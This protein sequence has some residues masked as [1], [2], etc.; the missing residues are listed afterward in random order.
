VT[1]TSTSKVL[2]GIYLQENIVS[3]G[4]TNHQKTS[5]GIFFIARNPDGSAVGA[6]ATWKG[7]SQKKLFTTAMTQW[8]SQRL[9]DGRI[10]ITQNPSDGV[11]GYSFAVNSAGVMKS[12]VADQPGLTV[13]F[14]DTSGAYL[15]STSNNGELELYVQSGNGEVAKLPIATTADKCVWAPGI[16]LIAYCAVPQPVSDTLFLQHWF[17]G[18]AH[19]SDAIWKIEAASATVERFFTTDTNVSVDAEDLAMD[20]TGSY[21][22]F[23]DASDKSLWMLRVQE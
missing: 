2:D 7:L 13:L 5:D 14:H 3:I 8:R 22:G 12:V 1:S 16:G 15:Y 6:T 21:I 10:I 4:V 19:T 11:S 18:V 20:E 9:A 23:R 17:Q